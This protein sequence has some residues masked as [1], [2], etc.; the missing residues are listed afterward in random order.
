MPPDP[1][2]SNEFVTL[3]DYFERLL[4][5][6]NNTTKDRLADERVAREKAATNLD[7]RMA[8]FRE[9]K[10]QLREQ[11]GN[12]VTFSALEAKLDV[13]RADIGTIE[14]AIRGLENNQANVDNRMWAIGGGVVV[15]NIVLIAAV[16]ILGR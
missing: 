2:H 14:K 1:L 3:R 4:L 11:T 6:H 7:M 12:L 13:L 5:E 10:D 8:E 15:I 16:Y 9:Y